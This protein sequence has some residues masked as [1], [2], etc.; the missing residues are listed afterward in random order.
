MRYAI[1]YVS[2]VSEEL[3]RKDIEELLKN[4]E[5]NNNREDITGLL[6]YSEGNFF[7]V[8]EGEESKVKQLYKTI[9]KDQRHSNIIKIL[10]TP[11]HKE[12]YDG[13]KSDLV[14]ETNKYN[15]SKFQTYTQYVEVLDK[16]K[17]KAVKNILQA[18]M[19]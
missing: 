5:E 17:Q 19:Q 18:L 8:I 9:E 3:T 16:P 14:T 6:L 4:S 7:Q 11:I 15:L 10:S 12:S 13:Y 2:T 1:S